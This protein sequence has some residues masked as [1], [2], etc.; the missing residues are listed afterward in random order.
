MSSL[1]RK[2]KITL[3]GDYD[4]WQNC[5]VWDYNTLMLAQ[6]IIFLSNHNDSFCTHQIIAQVLLFAVRRRQ[7]LYK[8]NISIVRAAPYFELT[9][10][11]YEKNQH[12]KSF[13]L[14]HNMKFCPISWDYVSLCPLYS[15][16]LHYTLCMSP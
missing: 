8:I 5:S 3:L 13:K 1:V 12:S 14:V 7:L 2:W 10:P 11:L 16:L 6:C 9:S 15:S 4:G